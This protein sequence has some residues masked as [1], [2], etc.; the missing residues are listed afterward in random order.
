MYLGDLSLFMS[1]LIFDIET[2]GEKFEKV[3][4][5]IQE[6]LLKY[7]KTEEEKELIKERTGLI[8]VAGEIVAIAMLNPE[9]NNGKVY[10]SADDK[11]ENYEKDGIQYEVKNEKE[12]LE[13]F[14]QDVKN[15]DQIIGYNSRGFDCPFIIFRSMFYKILP[16]KN[17]M[18]NRYYSNQ[19][20]DLLDQLKFYGAFR[21]FSLE[22]MCEF[23]KIKNPKDEGVSGLIVNELYE[24]GEYKKIAEYCMRD[25]VATKDLYERARDFIY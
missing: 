25:V 3:D 9:T 12:I 8:P 11:T 22:V 14:W 1:Q 20:L 2:R 5:V 23:L 24:K 7:A 10:F 13:S 16:T 6:N 19:H 17:L 18:P 21:G 15:Y 4:P